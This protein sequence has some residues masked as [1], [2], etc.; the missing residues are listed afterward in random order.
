MAPLADLR[1]STRLSAGFLTLLVL[2]IAIGGMGIRGASELTEIIVRFHDSPYVVVDS[3][4]KARVSFRNMRLLSRD[5][6]LA[7]NPQFLA[8][9][10]AGIEQ[11]GKD[12]LAAIEVAKQAFEGDRGKFDEALTTYSLYRA[13]L[14]EIAE[15]SRAGDRP[16]ALALLRGRAADIEKLY[17]R[18]YGAIGRDSANTADA[19]MADAKATSHQVAWLG[20]GLLLASVL[21]GGL[22]SFLISRSIT[23]PIAALR[24]CMEALTH[25]DLTAAVPGTKRKDE[26]GDMAQ[27]LRIFKE[28]SIELRT[29]QEELVQAAKLAALGQMSAGMAHEIN[30][31]LSALR[32]YAENAVTLLNLGRDSVAKE[33]LR[34]ITNLVDRMA[35][36]TGQLRQFARKSAGALE[37]VAVAEA[38]ERSLDLLAGALREGGIELG[39]MPPSS[40]LKVLA[41]SV[42]LQQVMINLLRNAQDAMQG[43]AD[44]RLAV[45]VSATEDA[46]NIAVEDSGPGIPA[47]ALGQ[48]FDP[49]Y[50]TK[51]AG[52]GLGLGLSI[53]ESIV[54]EF[55]G[56]LT[57]ANRPEGGAIFLVTLRRAA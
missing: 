28:N 20:V 10:E 44:R 24:Q 36:I 42:R 13:T 49:F 50:S 30:Q 26:I 33:N 4:A 25:G 2:T 23:R 39:W 1:I 57:A 47:E 5:L 9:T 21:V 51:A 14:A 31:P 35:R 8:K 52:E 15:A 46:V 22:A 6:V 53:S 40:D 37:P 19:F 48:I 3:M 38:I 16:A 45:S 7:D 27:A 54:R 43:C 29:K 18:Q 32:G 17:G 11:S 34:A 56:Q 55:A 12:Y 41:D